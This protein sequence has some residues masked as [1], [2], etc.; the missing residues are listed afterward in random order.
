VTAS[1]GASFT[2]NDNSMMQ[3]DEV[4]R[5]DPAYK[6]RACRLILRNLSLHAKESHSQSLGT[7]FGK[8]TEVHIPLIIPRITTIRLL[9]A[10]RRIVDFVS[11]RLTKRKSAKCLDMAEDI[12]ICKTTRACGPQ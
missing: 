4:D 7:K 9:V 1:V 2:A 11:S 8:L 10:Q 5:D 6:K 12:I 3:V